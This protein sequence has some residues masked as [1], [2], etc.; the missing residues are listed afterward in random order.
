MLAKAKAENI[1]D[2]LARSI[3]MSNLASHKINSGS[4]CRIK[5][6]QQRIKVKVFKPR[7]R[8]EKQTSSSW[9]R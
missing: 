6:L 5:L 2:D 7:S 1:F 4:F 9:V 3:T 8:R